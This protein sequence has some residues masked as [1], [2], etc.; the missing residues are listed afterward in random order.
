[1]VFLEI[2]NLFVNYEQNGIPINIIKN[3]NLKLDKGVICTILGAS[4]SG[5]TTLLKSISGLTPILKGRIKLNF[6]DISETPV[7]ERNIGYLPQDPTLFQ[8]L[9]VFENIAF[10]LRIKKYSKEE[11]EE[12]VKYL[13][14][15]VGIS[16]ILYSSV[17]Q[18]SGGQAQRVSLCR[19]L[20]PN[21]SLLLLDEPF[22]SLDSNLRYKLALEFKRIQNDFKITTIHVTHDQYEA[23]LI[24]DFIGII[25]VNTLSQ[26]SKK[27]NIKPNNWN[28]AQILGY[29][30]VISPEMYTYLEFPEDYISKFDKGGFINPKKLI[31]SQ[32]SAAKIKG[33]VVDKNPL[34]DE[35]YVD[36]FKNNDDLQRVWIY[37]SNLPLKRNL[38]LLGSIKNPLDTNEVYLDTLLEAFIPF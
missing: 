16:E 35:N 12:R 28:I 9:N 31:L 17:D 8:H 6:D 10:G 7:H 11:I 23:R 30:N 33:S 1:M 4:G 37:V 2:E 36:N 3:L 20:A 32:K 26:F 27:D 5:K 15:I 22:S 34:L 14:E 21:P 38:Y 19:A 29:P 18:I 13:A 24:A 25:T